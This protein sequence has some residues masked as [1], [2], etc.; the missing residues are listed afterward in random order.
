ML[1]DQIGMEEWMKEGTMADGVDADDAE[2]LAE[3]R[4]AMD[5]ETMIEDAA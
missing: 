1:P 2:E 5:R 3:T 4:P